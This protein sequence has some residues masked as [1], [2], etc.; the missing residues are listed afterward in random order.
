MAAVVAIPVIASLIGAA[1]YLYVLPAFQT[2]Q[3]E[4]Q[5]AMTAMTRLRNL[6]SNE[7]G[8]T[9]DERMMWEIERSRREGNLR[10]YQGWTVQPVKGDRMK[11]LIVF[12]FS[13]KNNSQQRAE[14]LADLAQ[15]TY[16]PQTELAALVFKR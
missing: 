14:W 9:V 7:A 10:S 2:E 16:T 6:P 12:S 15:N 1:I 4:P 5:K 3:L 13:R 8:L 11:V